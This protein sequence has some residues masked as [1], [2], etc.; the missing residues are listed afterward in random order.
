MK[1][2]LFIL[3]AAFLF[4]LSCEENQDIESIDALTVQAFLHAGQPLDSLQFGKIIP[5]DSAEAQEAPG[6]LA[7][8]IYS[9]EG[10]TYPLS[11][12]G[13][14]GWYGN[15]DLVIEEDRLYALEVSYGEQKLMAETYIP[16]QPQ[17]LQLS[18]SVVEKQKIS[19][20]QDLQSQT[21]SDPIE[22]S[23]Q[24]EPGTYYFVHIKNIE[25][26]PEAVNELFGNGGGGFQ[27]PNLLT[28]PSTNTFYTID[29]FR[30]LSHYGTY[31]L[32]VYQVNPEYVA[33]YEDNTG[34]TGSLNEIRTN[35]Q[36]GYGI[37]TGINSQSVFFEV[38]KP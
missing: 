12:L 36:N 23:W 37:F 1:Y 26:T 13:S 11:Y 6:N 2:N 3:P 24:G 16:P 28:E 5:L 9:E 32:V 33:L 31:E 14:E 10:E 21:G 19:S 18:D 35:V 34:G 15:Q 30:D 38:K 27:R 25:E 22:V 8:I 7:P 29:S 17:N 20:F 4:F